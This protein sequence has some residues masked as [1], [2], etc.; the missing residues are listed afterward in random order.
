MALSSTVLGQMVHHQGKL[1]SAD[2]SV[3]PLGFVE[4]DDSSA[5]GFEVLE[6][7]VDHFDNSTSL[8]F[9]QRYFVN[10]TQWDKSDTTPVLLCVGGE[11]PP[12]DASVLV[13]SV[14]CSDLVAYSQQ[15]RSLTFALEHRYY[16]PSKP[17]KDFSTADLKK[18]LSTEQAA[19]DVRAFIEEMRAKYKISDKA[20]W[21][22]F[23]GSYPGMLAAISHKASP[24][25]IYATVASSAPLLASVTM[26]G[27]NEVTGEAYKN[28]LVGGSQKCYDVIQK[29]H[30]Q[31]AEL[32]QSDSGRRRLETEFNTC[33]KKGNLDSPLNQSLFASM[34]VAYFPAQG[35][36]PACKGKLCNIEKV[37]S[38]LLSADR[39]HDADA[40][41]SLVALSAASSSSCK[42]VSQEALVASY[43]P[44]SSPSRVWNFQTC[45][46]WGFYMTCESGSGCPFVQGLPALQSS[47]DICE[48]A[49]GITANEVTDNIARANER[50][51]GVRF[52]TDRIFFVNGEVD[53]WRAN[54]VQEQVFSSEPTHL[55]LGTSHHFWTHEPLSTDGEYVNS[56]RT[57]IYKQLDAWLSER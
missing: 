26:P 24:D 13:D 28:A 27:Y 39:A 52:E 29:G 8:T 5:G 4:A 40:M 32:L 33:G 21:I 25:Y 3:R 45:S 23:G 22:T 1:I 9:S 54:S 16:G 53:P 46:E 14:H 17:T 44:A 20:P 42:F 18:Y 10:D 34:G 56:T 19:Q 41:A 48:R 50:Y 37:C 7:K 15:K 12:L 49:F 55:S 2:G 38:F 31:V 11:G 57:A 36:D 43:L 6:Q 47:L 51:G 35:N 30:A